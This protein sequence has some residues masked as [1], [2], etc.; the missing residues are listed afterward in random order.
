M[1]P[2]D[3]DI[4]ARDT[5]LPGLRLA[6]DA[7]ALTTELNLP[8]MNPLY[9]RYKPQTSCTAALAPAGGGMDAVAV[10]AY[11]SERY[12]EVRARGEWRNGSNPAIYHDAGCLAVV[13][14]SR[15][16][17]LKG[18]RVLTDGQRGAALLKK[19]TGSADGIPH[20]LRYKVGRRLVLQVGT[21]QPA[22]LVKAYNKADFAAALEGARV[23]QA[24]GSAP[25]LGKSRRHQCL[26]WRWLDGVPLCPQTR[27]LSAWRTVG[28]T[29]ARIHQ[30]SQE[31]TTTVTRD[32][33]RA[34]LAALSDVL[35][36]YSADIAEKA[37][38]LIAAVTAG[39]AGV[40]NTPALI[41]GDFSA[42][43]VLIHEGQATIIDWDRAAMG[44]PARDIGSF[45]ARLDVQMLDGVDVVG[46][47]DAFRDGYA[48]SS[49]PA[50]DG[51]A[52]QHARA[53]LALTTE[54][55]RQR[56]PDWQQHAHLL[57]QR[58]AA[59]LSDDPAMP[60][61]TAAMDRGVMLPLLQREIPSTINDLEIDL[62][63]HKAGRR[64]LLRYRVTTDDGTQCVLGKLR[65][66]G[67][68][69]RT[70]VLHTALR[71]R[72]LDAQAPHYV[73]VP[74][75]RGVIAA[76]ALWL[77]DEVSGR[78]LTTL[79]H[80]DGDTSPAAQTGAAL[81]RLHAAEVQVKRKWSMENE[82]DVLTRALATASAALPQQ[83]VKIDEIAKA[84]GELIQM[85][86]PAKTT[87]IHRDF[88]PDQVIIDGKKTWLL[89][90]D[91]YAMGDPAIDVANFLAHLDEHGLRHFDD[92]AAL[93]AQAAAFIAGYDAVLPKMDHDRVAVLRLVSLAR[94][95]NLSRIIPDRSHT[96][97]P[98]IEHCTR[99]IT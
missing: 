22:A 76:P 4:V 57:L 50:S 47:A 38:P 41:H 62:A 96:T 97:L 67:P 78:L 75:V 56:R 48:E 24:L 89:D 15:D 20:L 28:R 84:A 83:A 90:L 66:K 32:D 81:A 14:L 92:A 9:L 85:L 17:D 61:L 68:D 93:S 44:D 46:L 94:H 25:L 86:G 43:Q 49:G 42:D 82:Q 34:E 39:L 77:Q 69:T 70:P 11:T 64:A 29:L 88:Y 16:R 23:G 95:I 18:A 71:A 26:A 72:G 54:G 98:L 2:N 99:L 7:S 63:R 53:L 91:L 37:A 65:A 12:K 87:G 21:S 58:V 10:M 52:L 30:S 27:D 74:Q 45:L 73:G 5:N 36:Q 55:F 51:V 1:L 35:P 80:P 40:A 60:A 31:V 13:P 33:E 59:I 8:P 79:L 3:A 6:L 19:L